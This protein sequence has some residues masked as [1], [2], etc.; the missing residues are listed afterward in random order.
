MRYPAVLLL[1]LIAACSS[2]PDADEAVLATVNGEVITVDEFRL[3]YEFGH[4]HLRQGNTPREDY[5]RFLILEQVIAHEAQR[6]QLDTSAAVI[7][8]MHTL[9]EELLIERVFE[10]HVLADIEVTQAE[11]TA[12]INENAVRF[13][14]QFL[15]ARSRAEA[16]RLQGLIKSQGFEAAREALEGDFSDMDLELG[17]LESPALSSDEIEPEVLAVLR[18]LPLN[19][20]SDPIEYRGT[21]YL[22]Q[23]TNIQRELLSPEDY[24][25]RAP[26]YRKVVYNRKAMESATQFVHSLMEPMNVVTRREGFNLLSDA[27]WAWYA[28][29]TPVRNLLHYLESKQADPMIARR[30]MDGFSVPLVAFDGREWTI[31]MFLEHFTPGRYTLRARD[32]EHFDQRLANIIALVVRDH[33]LLSMANR[34]RLD[35]N[36]AFQRTSALWKTKW[37]FQELRRLVVDSASVTDSETAAYYARKNAAMGG[38][39]RPFDSLDSL[40]QGRIRQQMIREGLLKFADSLAEQASISINHA[41]L[42]TIRFSQSAVNPTMTVHLLKSNSNKMPFPIAD[43]NWRIPA[44]Q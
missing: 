2:L 5:L 26:S 22:F 30:L 41:I 24:E 34:E 1:V 16:M 29:E 21:W 38:R 7:H 40:D 9:R 10:E 31:R 18:N 28:Q 43:P 33:V 32:R 17:E 11:I 36:K 13:Q 3:N 20:V 37:L 35:T 44:K 42:D 12:E 27:L 25:M 19:A 6:M 8:A 4:G 14:F 39:L 15:P 23:V